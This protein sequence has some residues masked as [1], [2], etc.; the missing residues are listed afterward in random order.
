MGLLR[1]VRRRSRPPADLDEDELLVL[2]KAGDEG[3]FERLVGQHHG[4]MVRLARAYVPSEAAA[5][6][7]AQETWLAVLQGLDRFQARSSLRTWIFAILVNRAKTRGQRERRTV[8]VGVADESAE[9]GP[10]VDPA[11]FLPP[12]HPHRPGW[13][14]DPPAPWSEVEARLVGAETLA[15]V[16][17]VVDGLPSRQRQVITLRDL[18]GWTAPEVCE[19][20][21]LS[22]GNQRVLLHRARARVRQ[23]LE[24]HLGRGA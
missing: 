21:Q 13:W 3:A 10:T 1:R 2:L 7:V 15:F 5:E 18:E 22:E 19:V 23:A 8:P 9:A 20:L 11:R 6:E 4:S 16:R 14:A 17:S 24:D 12:D